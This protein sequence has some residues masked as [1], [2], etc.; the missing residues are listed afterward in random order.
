M[1]EE[2]AWREAWV[3]ACSC[4]RTQRRTCSCCEMMRVLAGRCGS[5]KSN[6]KGCSDECCRCCELTCKWFNAELSASNAVVSTRLEMKTHQ[7]TRHTHTHITNAVISTRLERAMRGNG[8]RRTLRRVTV[9]AAEVEEC[10][11]SDYVRLGFPA[12]AQDCVNQSDW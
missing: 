5:R 9:A 2:R 1:R 7:Q 6:R 3:E 12:R 10:L 11:R 8:M 4:A